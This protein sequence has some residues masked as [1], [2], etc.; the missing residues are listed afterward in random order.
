MG[1]FWLGF[2]LGF[3]AGIMFIAVVGWLGVLLFSLKDWLS[4]KLK[5]LNKLKRR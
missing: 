1:D 3:L 4:E 2:L 5:K